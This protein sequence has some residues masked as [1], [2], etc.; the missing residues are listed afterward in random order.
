MEM[1]DT[2]KEMLNFKEISQ[3]QKTGIY[4]LGQK[5]TLLGSLHAVPSVEW[6][7]NSQGL[8]MGQWEHDFLSTLEIRRF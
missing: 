6:Q 5:V 7:G 3:L 1:M 8:E 2:S 4:L